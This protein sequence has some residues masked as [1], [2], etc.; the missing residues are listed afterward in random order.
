[1]L[2][3]TLPPSFFLH[4]HHRQLLLRL[5]QAVMASTES[6]QSSRPTEPKSTLRSSRCSLNSS[7]CTTTGVSSSPTEMPSVVP[8]EEEE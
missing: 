8:S 1:R 6:Y 5:L 2:A 3:I 7:S 4:P